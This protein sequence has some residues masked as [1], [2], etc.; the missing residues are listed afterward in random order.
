[1]AVVVILGILASGAI[2]AFRGPLNRTREANFRERIVSLQLLYREQCRR[3]K[4]AGTLALQRNSIDWNFNGRNKKV[5]LG[6]ACRIEAVMKQDGTV[7]YSNSLLVISFQG[8]SECFAMQIQ[9]RTGK[10]YWLF[11]IGGTGECIE[12]ETETKVRR[13]FD[14]IRSM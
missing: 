8:L 3:F 4:K 14:E 7:R 1:M 13:Y 5:S 6:D 9:P 2:M 11:C 10:S 12:L